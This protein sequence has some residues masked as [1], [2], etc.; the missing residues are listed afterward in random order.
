[1]RART[2]R[3]NEA[4]LVPPFIAIN[5]QGERTSPIDEPLTTVTTEGT[6]HW[7]V[8]P[9]GFVMVNRVNNVPRG[10]DE[11]LA[12]VATGNH[13]YLV[14]RNNDG[15]RLT[16]TDEPLGTLTGAG[17]QSLLDVPP[18]LMGYYGEGGGQHAPVT[19]PMGTVDTRD[20]RALVYPEVDIDDCGFRMLEPHEIKAAMAF[21]ASYRILGNKR[22]QVKQC[23]NA[24]TPPVSRTILPRV[25]ASLQGREV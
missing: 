24:V 25:I 23:G 14:M 4:L 21:P 13:H 17:H 2:S 8:Q 12:P 19:Q 20:R 18:F 22:E 9:P 3:E 5:R 15:A 10:I 16:D 11:P 7:L 1:M 6:Q